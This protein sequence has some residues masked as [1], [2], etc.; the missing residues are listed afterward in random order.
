[1]IPELNAVVVI[2]SS[3]LN[4]SPRRSYKDSIFPLIGEKIIPF[5]RKRLEQDS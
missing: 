2:T 4:T 1:M 5:L 3:T